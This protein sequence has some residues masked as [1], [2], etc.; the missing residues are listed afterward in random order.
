MSREKHY[1][2]HYI[3][4]LVVTGTII[5]TIQRVAKR[6]SVKSVNILPFSCK[7]GEVRLGY[8]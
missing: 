5:Q 3:E 4:Y 6:M 8:C 1:V 2:C 7:F